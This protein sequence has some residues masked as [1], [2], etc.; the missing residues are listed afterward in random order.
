MKNLFPLMF[1]I[2][3]AGFA[4]DPATARRDEARLLNQAIDPVHLGNNLRVWDPSTHVWRESKPTDLVKMQGRVLVVNIWAHYCKPCIAEFPI[5]MDMAK[6]IEEDTKG[7]VKFVFI[8]ETSSPTDM[9]QFVSTNEKKLPEG[10][11][12][13]DYN[14]NIAESLRHVIPGRSLSLPTTIILDDHRAV[15]YAFIGALL[16][17]RSEL[18]TAIMDTLHVL[19]PGT[20]N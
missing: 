1:I 2:M 19:S 15:R 7:D 14:E 8:S 11:L 13:L 17:R 20:T 9:Q 4:Q 18:V 5:L 12:F 10:P 6:R 3:L 16:Y